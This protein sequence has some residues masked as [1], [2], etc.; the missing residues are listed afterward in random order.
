M[1]REYTGMGRKWKK[2]KKM[3]DLTIGKKLKREL[4]AIVGTSK[5]YYE[6]AN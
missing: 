3:E 1:E 4:V 5:R 2:K 6:I